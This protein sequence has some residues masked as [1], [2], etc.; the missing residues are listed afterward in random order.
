MADEFKNGPRPRLQIVR[1]LP[2]SGKTSYAALHWPHLLRFELDMFCT[3]GGVY[4]WGI[5]RDA[6]GRAW[7]DG[8]FDGAVANGIDFVVTGVFAG[9]DGRLAEAVGK[10][11]RSG[12]EVWIMTL[13]GRHGDVHGVGPEAR[14]SM[15]RAFITDERVGEMFATQPVRFGP[16]PTAFTVRPMDDGR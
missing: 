5:E 15:E 8:Q 12:Y 7:F 11:V 10:A 4:S 1:G 13:H 16:M 6:Q 9:A 3:R 2:G 14:A